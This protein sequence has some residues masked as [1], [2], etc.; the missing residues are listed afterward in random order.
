MTLSPTAIGLVDVQNYMIGW[1]IGLAR[2][3]GLAAVLPIFSRMGLQGLLRGAICLALASPMVPFIVATIEPDKT[4]VLELSGVLF[5]EA[6]VGAVIGLFLGVPIWAAEIA[7]EILDL[8]RGVTFADVVDPS[9]SANNNVTGTFFS[10]IIIAIYFASGGWDLTMRV[11]YDSYSLWPLKNVFPI[12]SEP[13]AKMFL[14]LLDDVFGMGFMLVA[15][16][17]V[18]FLLTDLSLALVA[19]AVPHMNIF[20]LSLTVKNLTFSLLLVLYGVFLL[21]YMK[22]NLGWLV[23]VQ[24]RL[25]LVAPPH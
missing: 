23:S 20:V 1:A 14:D 12:L 22:D 16:M 25:E 8:Q 10:I 24:P 19:K 4:P 2:I 17:I 18:A 13:S 21:T 3:G 11:V 7:G 15:P 6:M 9:F 5:K